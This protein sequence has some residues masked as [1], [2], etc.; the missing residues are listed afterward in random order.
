MPLYTVEL[1]A[2]IKPFAL[3]P[4]VEEQIISTVFDR[5][6]IALGT[7][8]PL[9][10]GTVGFDDD[11]VAV[12]IVVDG[13]SRAAAD[14]IAHETVTTALDA[15]VKAKLLETFALEGNARITEGRST[16]DRLMGL[17]ESE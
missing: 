4:D 16:Y 1:D 8:D 5:A 11:N 17:A 3:T 2:T 15:C 12:L 7:D 14:D 9:L 10:G 6:R 13:D